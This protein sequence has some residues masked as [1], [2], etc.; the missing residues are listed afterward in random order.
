MPQRA[1]REV[2]EDTPAGDASPPDYREVRCLSCGGRARWDEPYRFY[3]TRAGQP[4]RWVWDGTQGRREGVELEGRSVH[5]WGRWTV[6]E[7]FPSVLPWKPPPPK[8]GYQHGEGVVRCTACH[9]VAV[10]RLRW[11]ED[12]WFQWECRGAVLWAW[13]AEHAAV[14]LEFIRADHRDEQRFPVGYR[15]SLL[16][17]PREALL[18][19]NRAAVVRAIERS[20]ARGPAVR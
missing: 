1:V 5:T 17:L 14:I 8:Q 19:K 10:H 4:V 3:G 13:H 2:I 9:A 20:L 6:E 7:R 15:R 11:P 18:A 16:R 12:A